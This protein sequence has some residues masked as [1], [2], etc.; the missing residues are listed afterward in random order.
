MVGRFAGIVV[1]GLGVLFAPLADASNEFTGQFVADNRPT[2]LIYLAITQAENS[3]SGI[4]IL[5]SPNDDGGTKENTL[6]LEGIADGDAATL[7]EKRLFGDYVMT[8]RRDQGGVIITF[9]SRNGE[10]L[11]IKFTE[12]SD[13]EYSSKLSEW[14]QLIADIHSEHSSIMAHANALAEFVRQIE[15]TGIP[16]DLADISEALSRQ[17]DVSD[18]IRE[19][20]KKF[21]EL[22][23]VRSAANCDYVY[24][25]VSPYFYTNLE[26][27]FY[28]DFAPVDTNYKQAVSDIERRIGNVDE[29]VA[30]AKEEAL[31]L[32][33]SLSARRFPLPELPTLPVDE[34]QVFD[35]YVSLAS[36]AKVD[37][38]SIKTRYAAIAARTIEVM[39]NSKR[40]LDTLEAGCR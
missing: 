1:V 17:E 24:S 12:A 11:P 20:E 27:Y 21:R 3:I 16:K 31:G 26:S 37:V 28:T 32:R 6:S 10:V 9:P 35:K 23:N 4:M 39:Q 30:M 22:A 25:E 19:R 18:S 15:G 8:A 13:S 2:E 36:S 33:D 14:K 5:V 38:E 7:R 34:Q 29:V 40:T